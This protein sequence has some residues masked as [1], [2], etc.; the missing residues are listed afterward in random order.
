MGVSSSKSAY[1][2]PIPGQPGYGRPQSSWSVFGK[3]RK[4]KQPQR[5]N[6]QAYY[7]AANSYS[8]VPQPYPYCVYYEYMLLSIHSKKGPPD[9]GQNFTSAY[10]PPAGIVP[11]VAITQPAPT[12]QPTMQMPVPNGATTQQGQAYDPAS[13][14]PPPVAMPEPPQTGPVI[15]P[16]P[17][18]Q[19]QAQAPV[20]PPFQSYQEVDGQVHPSAYGPPGPRPRT[21]LKNPLPSP[22]KDI[23]EMS[24]YRNLL[25][26]IPATTSILAGQGA[27]ISPSDQKRHGVGLGSLFGSLSGRE[28]KSR[29]GLF[30]SA[31]NSG[32]LPS[33]TG[34]YG[35]PLQRSH[36]VTSFVANPVLPSSALPQANGV[37]A[38]NGMPASTSASAAL[39]DPS[40]SP[41]VR[42]D[43]QSP[44]VGFMNHSPHRVLYQNTLYPTAL[45]L[46][47]ALKFL[48]H[49]PDLAER[50]RAV[51]EVEDVYPIS[52]TMREF[53]RG[54]WG[55]A[56]LETA[57]HLDF[58]AFRYS[59]LTRLAGVG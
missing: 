1:P 14:R 54:D 33:L 31:S 57:S 47:E 53:V 29:G 2:L 38:G 42:F 18:V 48:P 11:Q 50:I 35:G 41:P 15:P 5:M 58:P 46:L 19:F 8:Y 12:I 21:P 51:K 20:I 30:R 59:L 7:S 24:P 44:L 55:Q 27:F 39:S 28:K 23:Y 49:R 17:Q 52:A 56:F 34:L 40:R 32:A 13:V 22:P 43:H 26:D 16:P 25:R 10:Y 3:A 4:G 36:T 45:H 6:G 37:A 9:P